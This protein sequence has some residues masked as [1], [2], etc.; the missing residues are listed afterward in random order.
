MAP[1]TPRA[2]G[3]RAA[4]RTPVAQAF[5]ALTVEGALIATAQLALVASAQ[6][7]GQDETAYSVPRGLTL[8]DEIPRYFRIAQALWKD[9][10][11]SDATSAAA[12]VAFVERLMRDVL[13]FADVTRAP[14]RAHDG[15]THPVTLEALGGRVP[16]VVAPPSDS[17]DR[18]SPTLS[19]DGRRTSA[20]LA[21]QDWLNAAEDTL[22]GLACNGEKL[23]LVRDN[24]SLTRPAYIE[25]D[26]R[27]MFEGDAFA[28]FTALW[29]LLHASRFGLPGA[30]VAD[31]ALE[32]WRDAGQKAGVAARDR[33]RDGVEEALRAFGT[34]FLSHPANGELRRKLETKELDLLDF[35]GLLLR[36]V[37]R[38]IFLLAAEDRNLLH[39]PAAAAA[40]RTLYAEGY[41]LSRLRVRSVKR[42][43]WDAHDDLWDGLQIAF[44]S[45]A[46]GEPSLALPALAGLF[47][48][49]GL[50]ELEACSLPNRA[51]MRAIYRLAWLKDGGAVV[52]V[53][54]RDM[55]TEELGSVYESLLELT[56]RLTDNGRGYGFAEGAETR[57]NQRKTTGSYQPFGMRPSIEGW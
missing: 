10:A 6:A 40:A 44:V 50:G 42:A 20:A 39:P 30:Q 24:P 47:V 41:S 9:L 48:H 23:R 25:A 33:L 4:R 22:W 34:G 57:G 54:W 26:L 17:L 51:L 32:R 37:Y 18:P 35:H 7:E 15:R 43:A 36:L 52:P 1:R 28:D 8:R 53:N 2:A 14:V 16:V 46:R 19:I 12:T 38:L 3:V 29:L 27:R 11:A 21:L 5:D 49:G 13:G 55:E 56:P 45:L 31:C